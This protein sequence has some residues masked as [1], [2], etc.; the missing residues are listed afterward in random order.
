MAAERDDGTLA[1][2]QATTMPPST[3]FLGKITL[4]LVSAHGQLTLLMIIARTVCAVPLPSGPG[5]WA[6]HDLVL[7]LGSAAGTALGIA[8]SNVPRSGNRRA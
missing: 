2:L 3:Y 6:K 7:V 5:R 1:R 4:V 8:A